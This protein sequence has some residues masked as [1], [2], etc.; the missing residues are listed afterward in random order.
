MLAVSL[1]L[2][3]TRQVQVGCRGL[4]SFRWST[5]LALWWRGIQVDGRQLSDKVVMEVGMSSSLP[6]K[7][8][9]GVCITPQLKQ[10]VGVDDNNI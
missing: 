3:V 7:Y 4:V 9:V 5:V 8:H 6:S 2:T 1:L 10:Q